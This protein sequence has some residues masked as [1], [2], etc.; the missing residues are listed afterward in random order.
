MANKAMKDRHW[1]RIAKCTGHTFD[2]ESDTFALRNIMEADLLPHKEDIE[3][4][5]SPTEDVAMT[6]VL[7]LLFLHSWFKAVPIVRFRSNVK[8]VKRSANEN[9]DVGAK[10]KRARDITEMHVVLM[11]ITDMDLFNRTSASQ[12]WRKRILR[13]SWS[14]LLLIGVLRTWPFQIS[15]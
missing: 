15:R 2:L 5:N 10:G 6:L 9:V 4:C 7:V 14:R 11:N 1:D 12:P 8:N 13:L 3:V